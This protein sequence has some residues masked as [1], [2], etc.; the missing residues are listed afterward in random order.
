MAAATLTG[1]DPLFSRYFAFSTLSSLG[2]RTRVSLSNA[3]DVLGPRAELV[4]LRVS[5]HGPDGRPILAARECGTLEPGHYW[6]LDDVE[7]FAAGAGVDVKGGDGDLLGIVHQT[8]LSH[9][10]RRE[11]AT[12]EVAVWVGLGDDYVEYVDADTG[13]TGGVF[14]QCPP[15]ND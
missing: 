15:L 12:D 5:F 10:N 9:E 3:S 11:I 4:R 6:T 1:W 2:Y 7:A 13:S 14:Y 8:P